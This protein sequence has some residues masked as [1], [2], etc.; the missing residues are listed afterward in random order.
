LGN[1][2]LS[3]FKR[4]PT[5]WLVTRAQED[6]IC[7]SLTDELV[8]E[9]SAADGDKRN[10]ISDE[11]HRVIGGLSNRFVLLWTVSRREMYN[12]IVSCDLGWKE[13]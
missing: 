1:L 10:R 12:W 8:G 11:E 13:R 6:S 4:G 3:F 7:Q 2:S 9:H 5:F